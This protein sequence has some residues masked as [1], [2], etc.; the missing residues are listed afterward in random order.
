MKIMTFNTQHCENFITK[1]I[2]FQAVA[3]VINKYNPDVVGLNEMRG[4]GERADYEA[5]TEALSTLTKMPY[6]YFVLLQSFK[7]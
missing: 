4:K 7:Q 1:R 5:Q 6:F 3:D 2:D